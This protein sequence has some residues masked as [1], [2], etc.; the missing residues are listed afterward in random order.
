MFVKTWSIV[1]PV[2]VPYPKTNGEEPVAVHEKLVPGKFAVIGI[3]VT[4]PEQIDFERGVF[5]IIGG[6][7]TISCIVSRPVHPLVEVTATI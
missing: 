1:S 4:S 6:A 2:P 5:M 3:L 7:V